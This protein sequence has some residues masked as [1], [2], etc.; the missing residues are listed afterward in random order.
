MGP[1]AAA[2]RR[3][4]GTWRRERGY[5]AG[6]G[7]GRGGARARAQEAGY[8]YTDAAVGGGRRA[9][10]PTEPAMERPLR[11]LPASQEAGSSG[12]GESNPVRLLQ[13]S[14]PALAVVRQQQRTSATK[15]LSLY[16]AQ[17]QA[18][19][20]LVLAE[21][22]RS[23]D[24]SSDAAVTPAGGQA[25][26]LQEVCLSLSGRLHKVVVQLEP[27]D[28]DAATVAVGGMGVGVLQVL[29]V[30]P[31]HGSDE[32]AGGVS[33]IVQQ[34]NSSPSP[35]LHCLAPPLLLLPAAV[36]AEVCGLW[37]TVQL[38]Q[39]QQLQ[40][41]GAQLN[42]G[43]QVAVTAEAE[44]EALAAAWWSHMAP[45]LCDVGYILT[46]MQQQ[47]QQGEGNDGTAHVVIE[48]ELPYMYD[49]GMAATADLLRTCRQQG[50]CSTPLPA[51]GCGPSAAH[52]SPLFPDPPALRPSFP[53]C[54]LPGMAP[55][56]PG[57]TRTLHRGPQP[58]LR[59]DSVGA[60]GGGWWRR[61]HARRA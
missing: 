31:Q 40:L 50:P 21:T 45:L 58:L 19:R 39:E 49:N 16:S 60:G 13:V 57:R 23:S 26:L 1:R 56:G 17:P 41:Q 8:G 5:C 32:A 12:R 42:G 33:G 11:Q 27:G 9:L 2:P 38:Q 4:C 25:L 55:A 37:E 10:G 6:R 54:C 61:S 14:I 43:Q 53:R 28:L 29:V 46:A 30:G 15:N 48:H 34:Q 18:V 3:G 22:C 44:A 7:R 36:A 24:S 20:V 52:S 59:G 51:D 35:L 47:Q